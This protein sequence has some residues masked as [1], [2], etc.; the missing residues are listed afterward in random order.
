MSIRFVEFLTTLD[1]VR[2]TVRP[3]DSYYAVVA[4]WMPKHD[5]GLNEPYVGMSQIFIRTVDSDA[6]TSTF[7]IPQRYAPERFRIVFTNVNNLFY[8]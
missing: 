8:I 2:E 6:I 3:D 7:T 1:T 4:Q 5:S